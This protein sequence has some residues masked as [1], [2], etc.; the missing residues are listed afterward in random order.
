MKRIHGVCHDCGRD[1]TKDEVREG[2]AVQRCVDCY[3]NRLIEPSGQSFWI[4]R[5]YGGGRR[6]LSLR[7][8]S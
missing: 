2:V 4:E 1:L 8:P 5:A 3:K 7:D 6:S